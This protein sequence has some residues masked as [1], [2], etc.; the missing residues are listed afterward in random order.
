MT[1]D[2]NFLKNFLNTVQYSWTQKLLQK[3]SKIMFTIFYILIYYFRN[4][5]NFIQLNL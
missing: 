4:S 5:F 3:H 2:E 1:S